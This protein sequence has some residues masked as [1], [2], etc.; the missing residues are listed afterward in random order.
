[1]RPRQPFTAKIPDANQPI[2]GLTDYRPMMADWDTASDR[3]DHGSRLAH[4]SEGQGR[5]NGAHQV[6]EGRVFT[7][8]G[9]I[10]SEAP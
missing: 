7:T 5:S 8:P 10:F 4:S 6:W 1:V 3:L 2:T 9:T